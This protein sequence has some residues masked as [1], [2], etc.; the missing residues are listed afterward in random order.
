MNATFFTL[1]A[2]F[3]TG[4]VELSKVCDKYFG[5][6][7]AKARQLAKV[8]QLPVPVFRVTDSQKSPMMLTLTDLATHLDDR[9]NR[10]AQEY[11]KVNS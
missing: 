1:M 5:L 3:G 2:E 10:A 7:F 4:T 8:H 9:H 11:H 6:S